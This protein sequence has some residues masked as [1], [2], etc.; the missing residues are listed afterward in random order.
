MLGLYQYLL[1]SEQHL[2][3]DSSVMFSAY[4]VMTFFCVVQLLSAYLNPV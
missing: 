1:T 3:L 2:S 4:S